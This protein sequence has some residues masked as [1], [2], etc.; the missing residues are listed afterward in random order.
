MV[1]SPA[2]ETVGVGLSDGRI[3][4]LDLLNDFVLMTFKQEEGAVT[5]LSFRTDGNWKEGVAAAGVKRTEREASKRGGGDSD[6]GSGSDDSGSD[7]DSDSDDDTQ[8]RSKS[9]MLVASGC[10][11]GDVF[12]WDLHHQRLHSSLRAC[13]G[14][15]RVSGVH[16]VHGEP[17]LLTAGADNALRFYVFDNHD[18]TAR[19]LRSR[20]GHELP[21]TTVQFYG[22]ATSTGSLAAAGTD[23]SD[24]AGIQ[25][26]SASRDRSVRSFH[27][28]RD[29]LSCELS[30]GK[31]VKRAKDINANRAAVAG[32]SVASS[33][34]AG[35]GSGIGSG[36]A[37][38]VTAADLKLAP[39]VAMASCE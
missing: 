7:S 12:L 20:E 5:S 38:L 19:L 9:K 26:L 36:A 31:L 23:G 2:A 10:E 16:F 22:A 14:N 39:V 8:E 30:Q 37:P 1:Q 34:A 29:A 35:S 21:P 15:A 27:A 17:A 33:S 6:S 24:G 28:V 13:H 32:L 3:V 11:S 4:I 25:L 18:G